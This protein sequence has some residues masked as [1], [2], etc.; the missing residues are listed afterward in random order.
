MQKRNTLK[1]VNH[2]ETESFNL[3][4]TCS[5]SRSCSGVICL[6]RCLLSIVMFR[7]LVLLQ[8]LYPCFFICQIINLAR[9]FSFACS[10]QGKEKMSNLEGWADLMPGCS[11]CSMDLESWCSR[12]I[13]KVSNVGCSYLLMDIPNVQRGRCCCSVVYESPSLWVNE[14]AASPWTHPTGSISRG[15][16]NSVKAI[17]G[18]KRSRVLHHW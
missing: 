10:A 4:F 8:K 11:S 14:S 1:N 2:V 13:L 12:H 5:G 6:I 7:T 16:S 15:I 3:T 17:H 18:M 9:W